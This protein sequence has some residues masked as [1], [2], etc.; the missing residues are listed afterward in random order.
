MLLSS[1]YIKVVHFMS[2]CY[3]SEMDATPTYIDTR[4]LD[5]TYTKLP[6]HPLP[7]T[8][9][10]S[11]TAAANVSCDVGIQVLVLY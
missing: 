10:G 2:A 3:S 9:L 7:Q 1:L 8:S 5:T 6:A 11:S 4:R